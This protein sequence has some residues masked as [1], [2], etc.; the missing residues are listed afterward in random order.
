M[1]LYYTK[2]N[3]D[4]KRAVNGIT[5]YSVNDINDHRSGAINCYKKD[6]SLKEE[7]ISL[8]RGVSNTPYVYMHISTTTKTNRPSVDPKMASGLVYNGNAQQLVATNAT[9]AYG[10]M[11]YRVGTSA[12]FTSTVA[13]VKATAAGSYTVQYYAGANDYS[14]QSDTH[15]QTVTIAKSSNNGVTVSCSNYLEGTTPVPS[16]VGNLSTGTVTYQYSTSQSGSYT[17]TVPSAA[18]TYWVKATIAADN[19]CYAYTTAPVS[20]TITYNWKLHNSGDTED[21]AYVISTIADLKY[22]AVWVNLGNDFAGKFFK[23][24]DNIAFDKNTA[25]NFTPVGNANY[26]FAGTFDG[27]GKIISGLNINKPNNNNVGLFSRAN[28]AIIKNLTLD[29][30]TITG[31]ESTGAIVG[32]CGDNVTITNC[33]VTNTVSVS[34]TSYVGGIVGQNGNVIGCVSAAAVSGSDYVGGITGKGNSST[35]ANCLYTGT[36]VTCSSSHSGAIV[37]SNTNTT[38]TANYYTA[39]LSCKGVGGIDAAG[40]RKALTISADKDVT[41]TPRGTATTYNVSGIT[42]YADNSGI[43]YGG[44]LYAGATEAVNLTLTYSGTVPEYYILIYFSSSIGIIGGNATDGYT[45]TMHNADVTISASFEADIATHWQAGADRDGRSEAKAYIITT[46]AGLDLLAKEVNRIDTY[47]GYYFELGEDITYDYTGLG[48][49]ESNFTTIGGKNRY[50]SGIFDGKGHTISGI[51]IYKGGEADEDSYQ[52][53]FGRLTNSAEVKNVILADATITGYQYTGGIVGR[54]DYGK[55]TDCHVLSSVAIN[56]VK[57][58]VYNHGGIA[59]ENNGTIT[60]CTSAAALNNATDNSYRIG[61][62]TGH[63]ASTISQCVYLGTALEGHNTVGAITGE[64]YGTVETCYFTATNIQGK[65]KFGNALANAESAVGN[66]DNTSTVTN[67][68]PAHKVTLGEGVSTTVEAT[69]WE[70]GFTYDGNNYYRVGLELPL[71]Y[72]GTVPDGY[73]FDGFTATNGGVIS[74]NATDGYTLTMPNANVTVS[75]AIVPDFA[76]YWHADADHDGSTEAKAY[77]I[78]TPAGLNLLAAQVNGG[79]DYYGK[80]FKLDADITYTHGDSDTESNYTAIGGYHDGHHRYFG[81]IFDG[82]NHTVSG[83]RIYKSGNSDADGYQGLFGEIYSPAEVK[84]VILADARITGYWRTGAIVGNILSGTVENCHVLDNVTVHAVQN[85]ALW[86]GVIAG[87]NISGTITGCTSAA[88]LTTTGSRTA[89]VGGIAGDNGGTVIDCIYLGTSLGGDNCVGAIVGTNIRLGTVETCYFTD[90]QIQGKGNYGDALD[91]AASAVGYNMGGTVTNSGLAHKVTLDEGI[92]LGDY[93][94]EYGLLTVYGNVVAMAY[95]DGTSTTIYSLAGSEIPLNNYTGTVP[96]GYTFNY[97]ATNGGAISGN[98]TDGYTLTMPN[99]NVTVSAAIVPDFATYWHADADHDGSTEA[100]AY[101][102]TTTAGLNLLAAQVNSGNDD[103]KDV[104]F[105]LGADITYDGTEN[106]YTPIGTGFYVFHGNL[107]GKGHTV[108]GININLPGTECV[109][110]FGKIENGFVKNL[111]LANSTING[112]YNVGGIAGLANNGVTIENCHVAS[113]VTVKGKEDIVGGIAGAIQSS[114]AK[115][116]TSAVTVSGN[117][118]VGGIAGYNYESS[119]QDCLY[120]GSSVS[121]NQQI[122]AIVGDNY[123]GTLANNYHTVNGMG[124]VDGSDQD[125][126]RFAEVTD[127]KPDTFGDATTTYGTGDYTGI[128]A[129]ANG[130]YYNGLYYYHQTVLKGDANGDG[131]VTIT[132]A[133]AIVNYILGNPSANFNLEA[134]NVNGDTDDEGK[135]KITITDAVAVVNII[136]NS[137]SSSAPQLDMTEPEP[138]VEPE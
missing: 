58:D 55:V 78:N 40:A 19:N 109:G 49:T 7:N 30:C 5:I 86:Y 126:A 33:R 43:S 52:G 124:G 24:G 137:G 111:T 116:C 45:I 92:T 97:T 75:A 26:S 9:L 59:G 96:E 134:A 48:E 2:A 99:A 100:K 6:G 37:G 132:D 15:S 39:D 69:N 18:G 13:D 10:S 76:T 23:L 81:G 73:I 28:N 54:N 62:I 84:N 130:L 115:G 77:I 108:S 131:S 102:I 74:G 89:S 113:S 80:Y 119:I 82:Q 110:L 68:G 44:K 117:G 93:A 34:G 11:Y 118:F 79:N 4:D 94:T 83:I 104:F 70:N 105:E 50:F 114:Y 21:D 3:F 112:N 101:I 123:N 31:K 60:G 42:A 87:D 98:A 36:S 64:N 14:N 133:V 56:K 22:L 136:L 138:M 57:S 25:N 66:N 85:N 29:N 41:I 20:F 65:D 47:Q 51:R 53:L 95:N 1:Y 135:P 63:N 122:G 71:A 35:I 88:A 16:L 103:Y 27:K 120:T 46:T 72:S 106:N 61:G 128:T 67:C 91:N 32:L 17:N 38:L 107:D 12:S 8:N 121:G 125:G 127:T 90:T 129:Y